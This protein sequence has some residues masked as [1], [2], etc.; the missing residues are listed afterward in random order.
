MCIFHHIKK[1]KNIS[2]PSSIYSMYWHWMTLSFWYICKN[3]LY[4]NNSGIQMHLW[5]K[6]RQQMLYLFL[7]YKHSMQKDTCLTSQE[8]KLPC[9]VLKYTC[10]ITW[11]YTKIWQKKTTKIK[12]KESD[13]NLFDPLTHQYKCTA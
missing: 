9:I 12:L 4:E 7:W 13:I 11:S 3:F 5:A 2:S 6:W 1:W 8:A 10:D